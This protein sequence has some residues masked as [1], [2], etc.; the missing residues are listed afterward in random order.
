MKVP[1]RPSRFVTL[2]V[3]GGLHV[4]AVAIFALHT[5][6][7]FETLPEAEQ[8]VFLVSFPEITEVP[9]EEAPPPIES[10]RLQPPPRPVVPNPSPAPSSAIT[11]PPEAPAAPKPPID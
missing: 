10:P 7:R 6:I 2:G 3:V 1:Q 11:L 9:P 8:R 4:V 5:A